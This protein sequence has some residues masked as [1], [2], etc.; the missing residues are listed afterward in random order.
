MRSPVSRR[1]LLALGGTG[2]AGVGFGVATN[3]DSDRPTAAR[4]DCPDYGDRIDATVCNEAGRV[5]L[6]F[7]PST[8]SMT[9]PGS[10]TFALRNR[11]GR[12]FNTNQ[13]GWR[14]HKY[15]D[16]TWFNV[17]RRTIPL[18]LHSLRVGG[19][20]EWTL[21]ID[22][23]GLENGGRLDSP[24]RSHAR[25]RGLRDGIY[26]FGIDGWSASDDADAKTALVETFE[27]TAEPLSLEPAPT[28]SSVEWSED[29]GS[30]TL[31]ARTDRLNGAERATAYELVRV[32]GSR[33]GER[34]IFEQV[35]RDEQLRTLLALAENRG[36]G[37]VRLEDRRET[38]SRFG[39]T[40]D[41]GDILEYDGIEYR[42][43][44]RDLEE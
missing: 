23:D 21:S 16:G 8:A 32:D 1:A 14:L 42:F 11:S 4:I 35:V 13:Y 24:D 43:G 31:V 27:L 29:D 15:E 39:R 44:S 36:A 25:F 33:S 20:M 17:A 19:S 3:A 34:I 37:R 41:N 40:V 30:E 18:P 38:G 28:V 2:I 10:I 6:L 26:A 22:N 9:A 7:E 12:T 5:G